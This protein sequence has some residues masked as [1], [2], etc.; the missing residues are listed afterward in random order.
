MRFSALIL[1]VG[2][3]FAACG[4]SSKKAATTTTSSTSST[5]TSTTV[6]LTSDSK[7]A[8]ALDA[9]ILSGQQIQITLGLAA[10]PTAYTG[11]AAAPAP[12]QGPLS[13]D[14]VAK[15]FPDPSYKGLLQ[16]GQASV[17][18]NRS[19]LVPTGTSGYVLNILAVKF[20]NA[21]GGQTFVTAATQVATTFG[22]AKTNPHPE[23]KIGLTPGAVL[24]VPPSGTSQ[25]ETVVI[26]S[27]YDDGVYYLV[28]TSAAPGT[29]KDD[30]VIKI[31][32]AEDAKFVGNKTA[33]DT[34]S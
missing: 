17:G 21:Q 28:S 22:G 16:Q 25:S 19:F 33:I 31:L 1:V 20:A 11:T 30:T 14:G 6:V 3:V 5:T 34:A 23:V 13:L 18:A 7:V 32:K 8:A 12:P 24:V 10:A 26:A 27:L 2:L 15:V 9:S 29:V 4:S